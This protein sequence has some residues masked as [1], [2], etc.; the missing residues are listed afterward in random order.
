MK[1]KTRLQKAVA[2]SVKL[3][4]P[5]TDHQQNEAIKA[6]P[7]I[8]KLTAKGLYSCL[9]CGYQWQGVKSEKVVCPHCGTTLSVETDRA[10]TKKISDYFAVITRCNGFSP[11]GERRVGYQVIRMFLVKA[12]FRKGQQAE[13]QFMEAFQ[14]WITPKG[15]NVIVSKRRH[16]L[17]HYIDLWDIGSKLEIRAENDAHTLIP[18]AVIG[19][20]NVIPEL[21]RNGFSENLYGLNPCRL[22][23]ALLKDARIET[24]LKSGQIE[25]MKHF[26]KSDYHLTSGGI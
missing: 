17:W 1:P 12:Y 4:P 20:M 7:H 5:L 13:Y 25:L 23:T 16:F 6:M 21:K 9:E 3:L 10:L 18:S 26:V 2:G 11:D 24:L 22:F 8:A 15:E 19:R 14:R